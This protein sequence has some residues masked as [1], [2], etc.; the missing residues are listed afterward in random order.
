MGALDSLQEFVDDNVT[1]VAL[2]GGSL[3]VLL[4][5]LL[6]YY[7]NHNNPDELEHL[8]RQVAERL[9]SAEAYVDHSDSDWDSSESDSPSAAETETGRRKKKLRAKKISAD[10]SSF[11]SVELVSR[12]ASVSVSRGSIYVA[13]MEPLPVGAVHMAPISEDG[14]VELESKGGSAEAHTA[15]VAEDASVTK[16]VVVKPANSLHLAVTKGGMYGIVRAHNKLMQVVHRLRAK[17]KQ[18]QVN[19]YVLERQNSTPL[20]KMSV[21]EDPD[22]QKESKSLDDATQKEEEADSPVQE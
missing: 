8:D 7:Y 6:L 1:A 18:E 17:K 14:A 12:D 21:H 16:V 9:A 3:V 2:T 19:A 4:L 5:V 13:E 15:A 22:E 10:G 20:E 11:A